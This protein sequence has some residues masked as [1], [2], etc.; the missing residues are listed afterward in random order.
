MTCLVVDDEPLAI[1]LLE[2]YISQVPGLELMGSFT[3][4]ISAWGYIQRNPVDLI[5]LDIQMPDIS[6]IQLA[7]ALN[8]RQPMIVFTSAYSKYAV[9][10]FNIEAVDYLLK[11]FEFDRF[12]EAI[13]KAKEVKN[14]QDVKQE[15][16][17]SPNS[18][19]VKS[20]YQNLRIPTSEIVY[21]EGFD[22]Y[23]RIH[24]ESGKQ[25]TTL[26][27]LKSI[28]EKLPDQE[29]IRIHRSYIVSINRIKRIYNQMVQLEGKELP[30]GKSYLPSVKS[31]LK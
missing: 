28:Q 21:I 29:F 20:D 15:P 25:V 3:D 13:R 19:I 10:G 2:T 26:M 11:P 8:R 7:K 14:W 17:T 23:I 4:A 9:E 16:A 24:L 18:I 5:F 22:D 31:L 1:E 6:G 27:T 12:L 30:I